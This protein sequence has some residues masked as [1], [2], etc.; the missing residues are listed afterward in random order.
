VDSLAPP[1][2]PVL[3]WPA[4]PGLHVILDRL[5]ATSQATLLAGEVRDPAA[6]IA[7]LAARPP[8]AAVIGKP[9][10]LVAG[11]L[12]VKSLC[13]PLWA[14]LRDHYTVAEAIRADPDEYWILARAPGG[15]AEVLSR[16]L[17]ERLPD[18][19]V[20]L[21]DAALPLEGPGHTVGQ[22]MRVGPD[23]LAG[24]QVRCVIER[25]PARLP[26]R[27]RIWGRVGE[28]F[29]QPLGEVTRSVEVGESLEK[30]GWSFTPLAGTAGQEIL[31]ALELLE[32]PPQAVGLGCHQFDP[33]DPRGDAYPEGTA[34]VDGRPLDADLYFVSY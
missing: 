10:G 15:R 25:G 6:V 21:L 3:I 22:T 31:W 9:R 8:A 18:E 29:L 24:L 26:L 20:R 33:S 17:E 13:P 12:T 19:E 34:V 30:V 1:R 11:K 7:E 28:N 5:P 23:D 27:L 32:V 16:P 14:W 2:A 4:Q